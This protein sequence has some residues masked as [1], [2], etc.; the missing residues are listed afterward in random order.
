MKNGKSAGTTEFAHK[1][2]PFW[3]AKR[4]LLE[5]QTKNTVNIHMQ[6][7]IKSFLIFSIMNFI[8]HL[9]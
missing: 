3:A 1:D 4:L 7:G 2:N 9:L 6:T 5:K 8:F